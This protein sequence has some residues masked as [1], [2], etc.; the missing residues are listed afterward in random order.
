[1]L[2]QTEHL[3]SQ[4]KAFFPAAKQL[5]TE[6]WVV[7]TVLLIPLLIQDPTNGTLNVPIYGSTL[8]WVNGSG[9]LD[10]EVWFG[11][12]YNVVKVYDGPVI[13]S[14]AL[15]TLDYYTQYQWYVVCK[16][17]TCAN[18]GSIWNFTTQTSFGWVFDI[19]PLNIDYWTGTCD[20]TGKTQNSLVKADGNG[21]AGWMVFDT[22]PLGN[23][24]NIINYICRI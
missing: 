23:D 6:H 17:D 24:P 9:T 1:M 10:V 19:Y 14:F 11:P 12:Y 21:Y 15:P 18:Q 7:R 8:S 5:V 3:G 22:T 2:C 4:F 13:S 16:N 20:P